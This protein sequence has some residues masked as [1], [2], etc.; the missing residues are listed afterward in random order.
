MSSIAST[1]AASAA[2]TSAIAKQLGN[3]QG[4]DKNAFLKLLVAQMKNQDPLKPID[5]T[6]FVAQLAQ[7]SNLEQVMGINSRLD[8]LTAQQQGLANTEVSRLVGSTVTMNGGTIGLDASGVGAQLGFTLGAPSTTTQ[9]VIADSNGNPVRTMD[10]GAKH[11]GFNQ[12]MWDGKSDSGVMQPAG[13]YKIAV[14][15]KDAKGAVIDVQQNATGV[16]RSVS[17]V[18]GYPELTL[19]SGL[20]APVSDLLQVVSPATTTTTAP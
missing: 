16:V 4:L 8:A 12:V 18:K 10:L 11:G 2:D 19:D 15:A 13:A 3:N 20:Q 6:D 7:F 17:F 5:N 14:S 1:S 9:I